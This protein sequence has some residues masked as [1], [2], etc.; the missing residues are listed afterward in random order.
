MGDKQMSSVKIEHYT[1]HMLSQV[2]DLFELEYGNTRS[3]ISD[4]MLNLYDN[5][6]QKER[7]IRLVAL[8]GDKIVGFQS[9]FFW[10]YEFNG[11]EY[12]SYQSGNSIVHPD[13]RGRGIFQLLLNY[14]FDNN[15]NEID[16]FIGFPVAASYRSFLKCNWKSVVDLQWYVKISNPLFFLFHK[17]RLEKF[18]TKKKT[19][20]VG[21]VK[22]YFTLSR[23]R[24]FVD[25]REKLKFS[26]KDYYFYKY[27]INDDLAIIF[28]L[29][30]QVRRYNITE[31]IVGG[32]EFQGSS[33]EYLGKAIST[34]MSLV[35]KSGNIAFCS[36]VIN[37][38]FADG[39]VEFYCKVK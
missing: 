11:L 29:K 2:V 1:E 37:P 32:I 36:V 21:N 8:D 22:K 17:N 15:I 10:P 14:I 23:V 33:Y 19:E 3:N 27:E 26:S 9:F 6:F 28:D 38:F 35:R 16:F 7:S 5:Q 13:Y 31:L 39:L 20:S 34:L 25:W 24:S 18:F 12:N 30:F 4:F